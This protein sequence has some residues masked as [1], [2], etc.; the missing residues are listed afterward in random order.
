RWRAAREISPALP[1]CS[2]SAV[3]PCTTCSSNMTCSPSR[4]A[5]VGLFALALALAVSASAVLA[6]TESEAVSEIEQALLRGDG[7]AAEVLGKRLIEEGTDRAAVAAFIGEGELL[8]GDLADARQWLG[9]GMFSADTAQRGYHA[10]A[11]LE[12]LEGNFELSA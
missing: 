9:S 8:Q 6:E 7:I 3:P 2:G 4:P 5:M 12:L 11:R 10:L 1:E